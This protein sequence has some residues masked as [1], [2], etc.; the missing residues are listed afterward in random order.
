MRY[1]ALLLPLLLTI[2]GYLGYQ[3]RNQQPRVLI[4]KSV[5]PDF[6]ALIEETWSQFLT[7]FLT[8][9]DCFGDVRV[10]AVKE[11]EDQAQYDP[12]TATLYVRVPARGSRLRSALVHEWAHHLEFQCAA[13]VT[14]RSTFLEAQGFPVDSSWHRDTG[15]VSLRTYRW[16]SIPSEQFAET[17]VALVLGEQA[18]HTPVR[19]TEEGLSI[20]SAWANNQ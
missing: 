16:A 19:I 14:I 9:S 3:H 10:V 20:I 2:S 6:A 5:A 12:A 18:V 13:Q 7:V 1:S 17:T 11:L 4:D 8:R 15:S